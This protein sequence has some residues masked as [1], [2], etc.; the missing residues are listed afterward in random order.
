MFFNSPF[1][2]PCSITSLTGTVPK[3][4][5]KG[6]A[7]SVHLLYRQFGCDA[8]LCP[9]GTFHPYGAATLHAGC[10]P[11]Q[12]VTTSDDGNNNRSLRKVLGRTKC[13][14]I[15]FVHGDLNGDGILSPREILRLLYVYTAGQNWGAQFMNWADPKI[16]EC[17]LNGVVCLHGR[18][19]AKIDLTDAAFCTNGERKAGVASDCH[20]LPS[21]LALLTDLE[22][23]SLNR[24][25]FL[26]GTIPTEFGQFR[27][28]KYLDIS[29]CPS[30]TG[31]LPTELGELTNMKFLNLSGCR[32]NGTVPEE[33]FRL[34]NL[35]KLHLSMNT[36]TGTLSPD[37][38]NLRKLKE[39]MFSRTQVS[40]SIPEEIG[41]LTSIENLEMYGN[42]FTGTIPSSLGNCTNLKRVGTYEKIILLFVRVEKVC[43]I[44]IEKK[45]EEKHN[46]KGFPF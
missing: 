19:V 35:E 5:C 44:W 30:M 2:T 3:S 21:E 34:T 15:E 12:D 14:G 17:D 26:R 20:G 45:N 39:L 46:S 25:Q 36:L 7:N 1:I 10:R 43:V 31:T 40:G 13:D 37:L 38:G 24:R 18:K 42:Q 28:L 8:V 11:C 33:L 29:L 32:F 4:L 27:K 16:A 6:G 22:V 41:D 9:P 23:L